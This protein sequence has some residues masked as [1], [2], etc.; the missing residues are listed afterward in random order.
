MSRRR[1]PISEEG[2]SYQKVLTG[3]KGLHQHLHDLSA[4]HQ[5]RPSVAPEI[6]Q[7]FDTAITELE[8]ELHTMGTG[9]LHSTFV[10]LAT[11]AATHFFEM[12]WER[13]E[14]GWVAG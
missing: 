1:D 8:D 14:L 10:D 6:L 2:A 11:R 3:L 9:V 12:V 7:K 5:Q 13:T 4:A